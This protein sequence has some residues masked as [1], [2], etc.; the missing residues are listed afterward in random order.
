MKLT[1]LQSFGQISKKDKELL[2]FNYEQPELDVFYVKN[3][4]TGLCKNVDFY[5]AN[6]GEAIIGRWRI[7]NTEKWKTIGIE[8][9]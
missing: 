3:I 9:N 2:C 5:R 4:P 6:Y 7:K 1:V 8:D